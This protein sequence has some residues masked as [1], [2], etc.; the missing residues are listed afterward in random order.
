MSRFNAPV[1]KIVSRVIHLLNYCIAVTQAVFDDQMIPVWKDKK[2][3]ISVNV[4]LT[5]ET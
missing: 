3:L 1:I 2:N 5:I 4:C